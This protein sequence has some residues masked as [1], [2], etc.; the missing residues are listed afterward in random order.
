M[1]HLINERAPHS[2]PSLNPRR[3]DRDGSDS[4]DPRGK[5]LRDVERAGWWQREIY[6]NGCDQGW[7][8]ARIV[9]GP[10]GRV[11]GLVNLFRLSI[12]RMSSM[13][14]DVLNGI[15]YAA[16]RDR[17]FVTGKTGRS[18]LNRHTQRRR[19]HWPSESAEKS[20]GLLCGSG[21]S[22]GPHR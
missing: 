11:V 4:S 17:L 2:L 5:P 6:A 1:K 18:G 8:V 7:I 22:N 16:N 20:R 15:A 3:W 12:R 9:P 10:A 13:T 14:P 21:S 19:R